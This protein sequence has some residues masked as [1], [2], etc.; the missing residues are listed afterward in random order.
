MSA[1]IRYPDLDAN[2]RKVVE[3]GPDA[4]T[5]TNPLTN[6]GKPGAFCP[7]NLI[8]REKT[9]WRRGSESNRRCSFCR[10]VPYHLATPPSVRARQIKGMNGSG[11][12]R[13]LEK[14]PEHDRRQ[15]SDRYADAHQ[16][17][18][19]TDGT[20]RLQ[21]RH[22]ST[23]HDPSRRPSSPLVSATFR[24]SRKVADLRSTVLPDPR[25]HFL[26]G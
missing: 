2:F 19:P 1:E 20:N 17:C 10:A 15:D 18:G 7:E 12:S 3:G 11:A 22:R 6:V 23:V 13:V 5:L 8:F 21:P 26:P 16:R 4:S 25:I 9:G 24:H 14:H